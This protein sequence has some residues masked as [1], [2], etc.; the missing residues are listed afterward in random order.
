MVNPHGLYEVMIINLRNQEIR[1][2]KVQID[3]DRGN[4][5][6]DFDS[7]MYIQEEDNGGKEDDS[8]LSRSI[9]EDEF[10]SSNINM[11]DE[12]VSETDSRE[13][14]NM[15]N[16]VI[17]EIL[18]DEE[19][20]ERVMNDVRERFKSMI[21]EGLGKKHWDSETRM[22]LEAE[23]EHLEVFAERTMNEII[24]NEDLKFN[25]QKAMSN[26]KLKFNITLAKTSKLTAEVTELSLQRLIYF[27]DKKK[28]KV[29]Y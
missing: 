25:L 12:E 26:Y 5:T 23:K 16:E 15:E 17:E 13:E 11:M 2:E 6:V 10:E 1:H 21:L 19:S 8:L 29:K 20:D 22:G 18:T 9:L 28:K 4:D 7:N 27:S 14:A 3:N 24:M